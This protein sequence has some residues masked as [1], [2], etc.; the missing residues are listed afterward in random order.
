[1]LSKSQEYEG[2]GT[3]F[4]CLR[5]TLKLRQGQVLIHPGDL[6]HRGVNITRGT[7][8]LV[9]CFMDGFKPGVKDDSSEEDDREEYHR[10]ISVL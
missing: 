8:Q 7:R 9:V 3:Y 2:G 10:R 5:Q 6:Y 4:R 1:M